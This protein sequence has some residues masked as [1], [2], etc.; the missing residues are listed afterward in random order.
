MRPNPI[1]HGPQTNLLH[2]HL[3]PWKSLTKTSWRYVYWF[4]TVF[5][6][7]YYFYNL[8][9]V[10]GRSMQPTL[11]PDSSLWRDVGLFN[12]YVIHTKLEFNRGD[13]VTLRSPEDPNR[14]LV[15][16]DCCSRRRSRQDSAAI[17]RSGSCCTQRQS[18]G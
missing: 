9:I 5:V 15:K 11:N 4:P 8:K 1:L 2:R 7:S 10:S 3:T 6:V 12:R 16:E 14:V 18:L 13:I 17:S